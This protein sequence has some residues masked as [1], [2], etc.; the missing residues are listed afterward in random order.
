MAE[1][2]QNGGP[3]FRLGWDGM[4][5]QLAVPVDARK[6]WEGTLRIDGRGS[7]RGYL[8]GGN[9]ISGTAN[10]GWAIAWLGESELDGLRQG[11]KAVLGI[12]TL[13]YDFSMSG[14]T[15]VIATLQECVNRAGQ[16]AA[17]STTPAAPRQ[18]PTIAGQTTRPCDSVLT[19]PTT[20]DVTIWDP[21]PGYRDI[22]QVHLPGSYTFLVKVADDGHADVWYGERIGNWIL[23][24]E[25]A[26]NPPGSDCIEPLANQRY[27]EATD[28]LGQHYWQLCVQ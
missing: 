14:S 10:G 2:A 12:G 26:P 11:T 18:A 5:W 17:A 25:W 8:T 7:G 1:A 16:V 28:N 22:V 20:C 24:G 21:E 4:Q 15:A 23:L 3:I 19:G 27:Q 6:D 13:D 9:S